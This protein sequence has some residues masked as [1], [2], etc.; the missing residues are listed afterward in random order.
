MVTNALTAASTCM[1]LLAALAD[2]GAGH[3]KSIG[4]HRQRAATAGDGSVARQAAAGYADGLST[5]CGEALC[6]SSAAPRGPTGP[7]WLRSPLVELAALPVRGK[8]DRLLVMLGE[9]PFRIAV[10]DGWCHEY[11]R[12][13]ISSSAPPLLPMAAVPPPLPRAAEPGYMA[14]I[15]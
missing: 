3:S 4:K 6:N 12:L 1:C 10:A 2:T 5:F 11:N 9:S 14:S 15:D 8:G 7:S 13:P